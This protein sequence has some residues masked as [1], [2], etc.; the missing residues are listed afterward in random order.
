MSTLSPEDDESECQ[1]SRSLVQIT[2]HS[3]ADIDL[4]N[5][6]SDKELANDDDSNC[7]AASISKSLRKRNL[8]SAIGSDFEFGMNKQVSQDVLRKKRRT[9]HDNRRDTRLPPETMRTNQ[10]E[11]SPPAPM[12]LDSENIEVVFQDD[13]PDSDAF[14][15]K[16][17]SEN[18]E[19][20]EAAEN[21]RNGRDHRPYVRQ[22]FRRCFTGNTAPNVSIG[23]ILVE[24]SDEE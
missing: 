3:N 21:Q 2:S 14:G 16:N 15:Q 11:H 22:V 10:T 7:N 17:S 4:T 1:R 8:S 9:S 5:A 18:S 13:S 20:Q 6:D 24:A 12:D 19:M 23:S